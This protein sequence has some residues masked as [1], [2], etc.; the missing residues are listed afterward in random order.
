MGYI[1][2]L[3]CLQRTISILVFVIVYV[4]Q[5]NAQTGNQRP[6]LSERCFTS[7]SVEKLML[8]VSSD[9]KDEKLRD[10][11]LNCFPNTLDTTVKF[12]AKN[13]DTFVITGD[14]NAMWLRDSSAQ[15]FP[16]LSCVQGDRS[17]QALI[18]GAIRRQARCLLI[19]PY[20]NA[21]N[22]GPTGSGWG[23]DYTDMKPELHE[24]KWEVDSHCYVIRL[25]Y[26]YWK[27]TG[28]IAPF[29][30]TWA[31]A[32][33]VV[34][35]TFKEQQR[36]N[37]KGNY[38]FQ[39]KST[40]PTDTQ[41]GY[42]WGAPV[43]PCGLIFSAF[44]PSD[45]A[46]TYGFLIPSNMF[47][48]VSMR[49]L[50]EMSKSILKDDKFSQK[51]FALADEVDRAIHRYA[52]VNH[53]E[54]GR[55]YAYE[56]DGFGNYLLMDDANVPSL[57]SASYLG[58]CKADDELYR[59]T[60]R[61]VWSTD[62]PYFF[63]GR[64]GEGIGGPHV[65]EGY[66][67]PMSMIMRGLTSDDPDELR[68]CLVNLRN[69]DGD[70]GFMH[71]SFLVDD[72]H[73]FTRKWFAWANNLFG[74]LIIKIHTEHPELLTDAS[75]SLSRDSVIT[76]GTFNIR[77]RNSGD[78]TN[79]WDNRRDSLAHFLLA[80]NVDIVGMQE[81][82][83]EQ[84]LDL[85]RL[86]PDYA[87][88][89]VGRDDGKT[90]GEYSAIFYRKSRFKVLDSGTFWLSENPDKPGKPGW[91]GACSRIATWAKMKDG[92]TGK[93]FLAINTHLDHVGTSARR[94][95]A[96]QIM[97]FLAKCHNAAILTGDFNVTETSEAYKIITT[98]KF[99]LRDTHKVARRVSGS[100]YTW[101]DFGR[102]SL[103]NRDKIDFIFATPS[104]DVESAWIPPLNVRRGVKVPY[105]SDHN[106]I[107]AKLRVE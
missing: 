57:L 53:P 32:M 74:E 93:T 54:Y 10:M 43:K 81:V 3:Q 38:S 60:R 35:D 71:E 89:G 70:T 37:G 100:S 106:P 73:K 99:V 66:A 101:H 45:D 59:N 61:F 69:T 34:Y 23:S 14:I 49:Q 27:E 104:I 103:K 80:Q 8:E 4:N 65:G 2:S 42:G 91:D 85:E 75:L 19:D 50:A 11:F 96:L 12:D 29:D 77:Y 56:V 95:G 7:T 17:L 25:A 16:Y 76:Y 58:Y 84:R 68:E 30:K 63:R 62:N 67:W 33:H 105:M 83:H 72:H 107:I 13:Q 44:R 90:K 40:V 51:C 9:I 98:D 82:T 79:I 94:N 48:V 39:R 64:D 41:Q 5:T 26:Y 22:F 18:V 87:C 20:A 1:R 36:Y 86:L 47:A 92:Q 97:E 88:I 28:D 55:I 102:L 24:R 21:F 31:Q 78:G 15:L 6:P 52:V 46:T